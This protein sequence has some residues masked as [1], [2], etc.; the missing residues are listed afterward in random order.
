MRRWSRY[1]QG[2]LLASLGMAEKRW[3]RPWLEFCVGSF[4]LIDNVNLTFC[5]FILRR[6]R[7]RL[8][9]PCRWWMKCHLSHC[10]IVRRYLK[11]CMDH[12]YKKNISNL[13]VFASMAYRSFHLLSAADF[14]FGFFHS[15]N[16]LDFKMFFLRLESSSLGA[17]HGQTT[18]FS[19]AS[20]T[21]FFMLPSKIV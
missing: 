5:Q 12:F 6:P 16:P 2:N 15:L 14:A 9:L 13:P 8:R 7:H 21:I 20:L 17:T 4:I 1:G 18:F 10:Q 3:K 19:K 11:I